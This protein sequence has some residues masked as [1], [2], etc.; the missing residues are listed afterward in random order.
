LRARLAEVRA[1]FRVG[2]MGEALTAVRP[3]V[4]DAKQIGYGPLLAEALMMR[5]TLE[6]QTFSLPQA[7]ETLQQAY[8]E[9]QICRYDEVAAESAVILMGIEGYLRHRFESAEVWARNAEALLRRLG[10]R[11]RLWGW[12]FHGRSSIR[13]VQGRFTEA[14]EDT[15]Q[16]IEANTRAFGAASIDAG[17]TI[18][19]LAN[20]L[21]VSGD[22]EGAL[23]AHQQAFAVL[24]VAASV[25][26]PWVALATANR[27]QVLFRLGR[28][29]EATETANLALE[30]MESGS[31][32]RGIPIT[33]PLRTL[34]LCHLALGRFAAARPVLERAVSIREEVDR[35]PLRL[36][37]VHFAL[38]RALHE[39]GERRR[40]VELARQARREYEQAARTPVAEKDL[41]EL[42]RWLAECDPA[43]RPKR[44]K[45][46]ARP[47]AKSPRKARP[48]RK[49]SARR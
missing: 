25:D 27:A 33:I 31:D 4:D 9:A 3:L 41:A 48:P 29:A 21:G 28:F 36:G 15:R 38:A 37:E 24:S 49:S 40:A 11:D 1:A 43:A 8:S 46:A 30:R 5:G 14:V 34:G 17:M 20:Q 16:A 26:H 22:F 39:T 44:P 47:R 2:R 42:D 13:E 35:S 12:F 7:V 32:P 23:A 19:T 6:H 10:P 45:R 18:V